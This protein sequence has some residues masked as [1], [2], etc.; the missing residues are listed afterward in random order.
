MDPCSVHCARASR[1][2]TPRSA[3]KDQESI[4]TCSCVSGRNDVRRFHGR[5]V[6]TQLVPR[7]HVSVLSMSHEP[8]TSLLYPRHDADDQCSDPSR[9]ARS[10]VHLSA[11]RSS[12]ACTSS[13]TG[14]ESC[15][16]AVPSRS[17][18]MSLSCPPCPLVSRLGNELHRSTSYS[19][20][21]R[22]DI[23]RLPEPHVSGPPLERRLMPVAKGD[24]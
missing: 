3:G 9:P 23:A 14:S 17:C 20:F 1:R 7:W 10:R 6:I 16:I 19:C 12:D 2:I 21:L 11:S 8:S 5:R 22:R 4:G 24:V 18:I 15:G 13:Q